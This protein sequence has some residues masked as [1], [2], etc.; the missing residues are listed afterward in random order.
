MQDRA[1]MYTGVWTTASRRDRPSLADF[2]SFVLTG[3]HGPPGGIYRTATSPT[4]RTR[5]A[6]HCIVILVV[7]RSMKP[8]FAL[9]TEVV[10]HR[11]SHS[12]AVPVCKCVSSKRNQ[13]EKV[14]ICSCEN[15]QF[16]R[17]YMSRN[18]ALGRASLEELA[19]EM[20]R[21]DAHR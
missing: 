16:V 20:R 6:P 2:G 13:P 4:T 17:E 9:V 18:L 15:V 7:Y 14:F 12:T 19:V 8:D 3:L 5:R 1:C 10:E 21:Y 11:K